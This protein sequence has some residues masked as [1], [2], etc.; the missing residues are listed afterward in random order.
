MQT[1]D[2][3]VTE[4]SKADQTLSKSHSVEAEKMSQKIVETV[5]EAEVAAEPVLEKTKMA[6]EVKTEDDGKAFG[7]TQQQKSVAVNDDFFF[8]RQDRPKFSA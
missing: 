8:M 7:Q 3:Q 4:E 5:V 2:T 6:E 1:S